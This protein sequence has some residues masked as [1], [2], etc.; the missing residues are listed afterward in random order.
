M[1]IVNWTGNNKKVAMCHPKLIIGTP[2]INKD[3]LM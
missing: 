2:I 1:E 3:M